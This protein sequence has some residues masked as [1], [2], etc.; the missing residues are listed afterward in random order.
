MPSVRDVLKYT[1]V[2]YSYNA[3]H[4]RL[5]KGTCDSL[6]KYLLRVPRNMKRVS[7]EGNLISGSSR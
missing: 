2:L 3:Y 4:W 7:V 1:S 6:A 5:S